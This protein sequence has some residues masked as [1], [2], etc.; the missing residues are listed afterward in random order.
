MAYLTQP[1]AA[2]RVEV[3]PARTVT[4]EATAPLREH[5]ARPLFGWQ[6]RMQNPFAVFLRQLKKVVSRRRHQSLPCMVLVR[7]EAFSCS[8]GGLGGPGQTPR[9]HTSAMMV[10]SCA[11]AVVLDP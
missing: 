11:A 3:F 6:I 4:Q 1:Q 7:Y 10:N 8:K 9:S 5:R 2:G